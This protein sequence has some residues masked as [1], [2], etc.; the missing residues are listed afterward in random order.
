MQELIER[1]GGGLWAEYD[2]GSPRILSRRPRVHDGHIIPQV[3][4]EM[5]Q[6]GS[7]EGGITNESGLIQQRTSSR[8]PL[9]RCR[10][11]SSERATRCP[12]RTLPCGGERGKKKEKK[13]TTGGGLPPHSPAVCPRRMPIS[14]QPCDGVVGTWR[15]TSFVFLTTRKRLPPVSP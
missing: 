6:L 11:A 2:A 14:D 7:P 3:R 9:V 5:N 1:R 4:R 15:S 13:G 10:I 8:P 12:C